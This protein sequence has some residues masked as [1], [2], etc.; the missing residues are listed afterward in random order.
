V[1]NPFGVAVDATDLYWSNLNT[2][3]IGPANID[4][5]S[6]APSFISL[7]PAATRPSG[8]TIGP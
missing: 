8:L 6:P 1:N 2:G 5:S 7:T 3:T 4:G